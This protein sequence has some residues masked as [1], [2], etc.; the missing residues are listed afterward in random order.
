MLTTF[1]R[2]SP[3]D[4]PLDAP[5]SLRQHVSTFHQIEQY[6]QH[7][8]DK[9]GVVW[10]SLCISAAVHWNTIRRIYQRPSRAEA[11]DHDWLVEIVSAERLATPESSSTGISILKA[12]VQAL[13]SYG[14]SN[15]T[16]EL[17]IGVGQAAEVLAQVFSQ[18]ILALMPYTTMR[19]LGHNLLR[20]TIS[21]FDHL[22][23][24]LRHFCVL[25]NR[26]IVKPLLDGTGIDAEVC[27]KFL[28]KRSAEQWGALAG[29]V[30][31]LFGEAGSQVIEVQEDEDYEEFER[32]SAAEERSV[33]SPL[34]EDNT[35]TA[36]NGA[37][38]AVTRN[39]T[40]ERDL[41]MPDSSTRKSSAAASLVAMIDGVD[42]AYHAQSVKR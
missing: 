31:A 42:G 37:L 22:R 7:V 1:P 18:G 13:L 35:N 25:L 34:T 29:P 19:D 5:L 9:H 11:A 10:K 3:P 40:P 33:I 2:D 36:A 8:A 26:L 12:H 17:V 27:E 30:A 24:S 23:P 28:V 39:K 20:K 38:D 4:V 21:E 6:N 32:E 14:P 41:V 15:D 16:W